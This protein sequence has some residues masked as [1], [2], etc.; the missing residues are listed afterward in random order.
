VI[1]LIG[2][3]PGIEWKSYQEKRTSRDDINAWFGGPNPP[4]SNIGIVTGMVS[5]LVVVDCDSEKA[6]DHW[7]GNF[8]ESPIV[9]ET[10]RGGS[11]HY[12]R[13][14]LGKPLRSRI[15]LFSQ[16]IDLRGEGGYVVAPPS[17]HPNGRQY[18]WHAEGELLSGELPV[19]DRDWLT[20]TSQSKASP[21]A[22]LPIHDAAAYIGKIHAVSGSGGHNATYR[23]ACV[24]RDAGLAAE[25]A[26]AALI[27]WN[28]SNAKPP[29]SVKELLHKVKDAYR[30][31]GS[32]D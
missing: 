3:R 20:D 26:L 30:T 4:F 28:E 17:I 19:F 18:R 31:G 27:A 22:K 12:Y 11:H 21:G 2:K 25:D 10:G 8:P 7:T 5:S 32:D 1:P 6:T 9:V 13:M 24:L 14:P 23:A 16:A 15:K 29:W